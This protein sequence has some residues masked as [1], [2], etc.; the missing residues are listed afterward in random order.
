MPFSFSITVTSAPG[1]FRLKR[2]AVARP[3]MPPPTTRALVGFRTSPIIGY[4]GGH[5][6]SHQKTVFGG[7]LRARRLPGAWGVTLYA[8]ARGGALYCA[9]PSAHGGGPDDESDRRDGISRS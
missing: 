6:R 3:T 8:S 2:N 4:P 1:S 9:K 7:T 5:E